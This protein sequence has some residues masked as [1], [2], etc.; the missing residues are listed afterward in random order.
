MDAIRCQT[1]MRVFET[2]REELLPG[3]EYVSWWEYFEPDEEGRY[4]DS[5]DL[6]LRPGSCPNCT[7]ES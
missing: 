6:A 1:C 3:Y 5:K 7:I 4:E 2:S